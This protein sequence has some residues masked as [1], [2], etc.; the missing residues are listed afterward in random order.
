VELLTIDEFC[1]RQKISR[2]TYYVLKHKRRGPRVIRIGNR[3][4][5]SE[6]SEADW[7]REM[8]QDAA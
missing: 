2:A 7:R 3:D 1:Q 4:R 6:E 5:I 8:E